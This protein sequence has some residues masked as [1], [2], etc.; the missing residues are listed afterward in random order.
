VYIITRMERKT[1]IVDIST[2]CTCCPQ[3]V[4]V[5]AINKTEAMNQ[6]V[7]W[8]IPWRAQTLAEA[9]AGNAAWAVHTHE[10]F[11]PEI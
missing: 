7:G 1:Y 2:G 10:E 8:G 6:A 4:K 3:V 9:K 11:M 5:A